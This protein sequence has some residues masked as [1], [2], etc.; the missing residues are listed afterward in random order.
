MKKVTEQ[1]RTRDLPSWD[2]LPRPWVQLA[3][4]ARDEILR[5]SILPF[6]ETLA[7]L[8]YHYT[9]RAVLLEPTE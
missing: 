2:S 9:R 6:G 5:T 3:F 8:I 4:Q 7:Y 1:A